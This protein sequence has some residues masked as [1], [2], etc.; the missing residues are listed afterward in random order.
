[1]SRADDDNDRGAA[2]LTIILLAPVL[3]VLMF[4][5]FQA[6]MWNHTRTEARVIARETAVLVA[7]DRMPPSQAQ[8]AAALSLANDSV[9]TGTRVWIDTTAD[10]VIVTITGDA[11]GVL[12]GTSAP[13]RVKVA[14]P[15]E[16]WVPL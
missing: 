3:V 11:P 15:M 8:A 16:G 1:V 9:L 12:R 14:V 6:A 2:S 7:R 10:A 5:G 4:A 13:V